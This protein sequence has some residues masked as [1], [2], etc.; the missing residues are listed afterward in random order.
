MY[1][2]NPKDTTVTVDGVYL[3]GMGESMVEF[4]FDEDNFELAVGAQGDVV[5]NESNNKIATFKVTLQASSPQYSMM[6]KYA[7]QGKI[8]PVWGVNKSIGER[9]GGTQARI[10]KSAPVSYGT[11]LEE[12]EF[13]MA[14]ADGVHEAC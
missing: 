6:L 2:Y 4:E 12:R 9:F 10:K 14:V 1:K 3:T 13:E 5:M 8:F 11:E 7:K